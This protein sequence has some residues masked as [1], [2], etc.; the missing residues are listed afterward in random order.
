MNKVCEQQEIRTIGNEEAV[1]EGYMME[2]PNMSLEDI[3]GEK[4]EEMA[5]KKARENKG[6]G[7][8]IIKRRRY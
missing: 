8:T 2:T 6:K 5:Q 4:D 3:V 7:A 1:L